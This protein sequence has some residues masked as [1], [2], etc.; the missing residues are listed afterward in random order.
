MNIDIL[1]DFHKKLQSFRSKLVFS[2]ETSSIDPY[3]GYDH[4]HSWEIAI[5]VQLSFSGF[6]VKSYNE[7]GDGNYHWYNRIMWK[8]AYYDVDL[9]CHHLGKDKIRIA[10]PN[11]LHINTTVHK[12]E[13]GIDYD[14]WL[15]SEK[16]AHNSNLGYLFNKD[17]RDVNNK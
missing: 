12:E 17:L 6:F 9:A 3:L 16:L 5:L 11:V 14:V 15:R 7:Y 4:G 2:E 8:G 10:L 1:L 13:D